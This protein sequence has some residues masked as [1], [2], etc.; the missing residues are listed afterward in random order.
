[1]SETHA[2]ELMVFNHIP[3][4]GG[5][6]FRTILE[7]HY[8]A[9]GLL[10]IGE[11]DYQASVDA[12]K[13]MDE[14]SK[15]QI[16]C[17]SGHIPFGIHRYFPGRNVRY[18]SFVRDPVS[19][20]ISEFFYFINRP[21]ILP[22]IGV[23]E[24]TKLDFEQFM[25]LHEER[26][27]FNIQTRVLGG[28]NNMLEHVLS[29]YPALPTDAATQLE[30]IIDHYYVCVGVVERFDESM[31]AIQKYLSLKQPWYAKRNVNLINKDKARKL[32]QRYGSEIRKLNSLDDQ[33]YHR[34]T[35]HLD[36]QINTDPVRHRRQL[37]HFRR[38]NGIYQ[39]LQNAYSYLSSRYGFG[40]NL[41]QRFW[42]LINR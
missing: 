22:L 26:R 20:T 40:L 30:E 7:R 21:N 23:E 16:S 27:L 6:T 17:I 2:N 29:P 35:A 34:I 25:E 32:E 36:L 12:I 37:S 28:F 38:M 4:T 15:D 24:N 10:K 13:D 8:A 39:H 1:M 9:G 31:L 33:L 5:M 42:S 41:G 14:Q 3:K 18:V 19:R 11:E